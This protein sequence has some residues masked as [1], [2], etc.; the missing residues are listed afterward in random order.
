MIRCAAYDGADQGA[1]VILSGDGE[2]RL[3]Q[4]VRG[5]LAWDESL[6]RTETYSGL[7]REDRPLMPEPAVREAPVNAVVHRDCA[8]TGSPVLV[9]DDRGAVTSPGSLPNH[10]TVDSVR[11]GGYPRSRN[12]AMPHAVS[13]ARLVERRGRGWLT[14]RRSMRAFN[15]A[16]PELLNDVNNRFVR[17]NFRLKPEPAGDLT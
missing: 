12:E 14:M 6:G 9:F 1:D 7:L 16:E 2:G 17:V 15:D 3:D 11:V 5:A 8:V 4:Q 13:V 10:M